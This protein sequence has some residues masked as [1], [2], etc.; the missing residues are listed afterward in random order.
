MYVFSTIRV[1]C[2]VYTGLLIILKILYRDAL[3]LEVVIYSV[4]RDTI[5][6]LLAI[7]PI[8]FGYGLQAELN[9]ENLQE[10]D[11]DF[12][13]LGRMSQFVQHL[14]GFFLIFLAFRILSTFR[15]FPYMDWLANVLDRVISQLQTFYLAAAP[16]FVVMTVI[17]YFISGSSVE[18]TSTLIRCVFTVIRFS[19]GIGNSSDYYTIN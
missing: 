15:I 6:I 9:L 7:L 18:E 14:D 16:F 13:R 4:I 17:L 5:Y 12:H 10:S 11:V 19:L 1:I 3:G 8:A 2:S